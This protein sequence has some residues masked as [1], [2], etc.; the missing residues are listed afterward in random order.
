[1]SA[2]RGADRLLLAACGHGALRAAVLCLAATASAGAALALPAA[3]GKTL[4]LLLAGAAAGPWLALCAGLMGALVLLDAVD[5]V[6]TGTL[7]SRTTAWLRTCLLGHVLALG[8][9]RAGGFGHGDLV[10]R[11]TGNAAH[12]GTGPSAAASA[13]AA[14]VTPVG[15]L[16]ALALLDLR[17]AAVFLAG[18]PAL[19][20]LL[21]AFS[22]TSS[23]CVTRYQEAQAR[24]A[25]R[26]V[27]A[28]GGARTI[29]AA[30]IRERERA[31]VLEPLGELG[32][33]GHRM[34]RVQGRATG[35]AAVLV[36]LLQLA[37]V[38]VGGL[39]LTAGQ[40]SVGGLVAAGAYAALAAGIGTLVG[41]LNAL[42]RGHAAARR[43]SGVL[44]VPAPVYGEARAAHAGRAEQ[45]AARLELRGVRA[46]RGGR[47]VLRGVDLTVPAGATVAVVGRSGAGKSLL[48]ALAGRLAEPEAGSVLLDGA[49]LASLDRAELRR[50]VGYAFERPVLFGGTVGEAIAAGIPGGEQRTASARAARVAGAAR[51]ARADGFVRT[52]P[53]GYDTP[54]EEAPLSGGEVQRLGLAR[55]FAHRG[56]LLILDDATSSLDTVTE[57]QVT[58]ALLGE[59][60]RTGTRAGT[61]LV[62]AHRASTAARA[63]LTA[64]LEDGRVRALAPHDDLWELPAYRALFG[65]G[66]RSEF[67][68]DPDP[69]SGSGEEI[70]GG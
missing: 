53:R 13:L 20:L 57:L 46:S 49:D 16:V 25:G 27:E 51:A 39:L 63:D 23:D 45:G 18:T 12:A 29:A 10:T 1:M 21:R 5:T 44:D 31:R 59:G 38:A 34:W 66:P 60:D 17:L 48:A 4:D 70:A 69:R 37:V 35:Q 43:L 40:L 47:E 8:P 58:R 26:L 15:G 65:S 19:Y 50:A 41:Q 62:V 52:L 33:H 68:P 28:L 11:C 24:I 32:E 9:A 14:L 22:R 3:L 2:R 61:R 36:P 67:D 55:A 30:G 56:R 42:V 6:L 54:C 7:N 64:W